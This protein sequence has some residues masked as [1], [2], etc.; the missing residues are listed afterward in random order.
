MSNRCNSKNFEKYL[1]PEGKWLKIFP[2]RKIEFTKK[3]KKKLKALNISQKE[4][5]FFKKS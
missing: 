3:K 5:I 1:G 2:Q 4:N